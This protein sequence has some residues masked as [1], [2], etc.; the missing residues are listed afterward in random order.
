M[1]EQKAEAETKA[2]DAAV[3]GV[4]TQ[5][6]VPSTSST[7]STSSFENFLR[8]TLFDLHARSEVEST[9]KD[10]VTDVEFAVKLQDQLSIRTHQ[11]QAE[12]IIAEQE[13]A[14]KETHV[15]QKDRLDSQTLLADAMVIDLWTLSKELGSLLE[16]KQKHETM[17]FEY[18]ELVA[19]LAQAEEDLHAARN[20]K[21]QQ[22]AQ[23]QQQQ[24][25]QQQPTATAPTTQPTPTVVAVPPEKP[26]DSPSDA[27]TKTESS[28]KTPPPAAA[29]PVPAASVATADTSSALSTEPAQAATAP[30]EPKEPPKQAEE[31]KKPQSPAP[32]PVVALVEDDQNNG[33]PPVTLETIDMEILMRIFGF[34][35]AYDILNTAQVNISMYSRVDSLFGFGMDAHMQQDDNVSTTSTLATTPTV[36]AATSTPTTASVSTAAS[37]KAPPPAA[38][39]PPPAAAKP[40][41]PQFGQR[42]VGGGRNILNLLQGGRGGDANNETAGKRNQSPKRRGG[43]GAGGRSAGDANDS[44]PPLSEAMAHSMAAKLND[45]EINA[46]I[47]MTEKLRSKEKQVALLIKEKEELEGKLSGSE[48]VKEFLIT[49]VRDMEKIVNKN[50][51]TEKKVTQQIASDQEVIAFLDGRVQELERSTRVIQKDKNAIQDKLK[52]VASQNDK[53]VAVLSDMLQFERQKLK[54]NEREWKATKK[55]LVKE[56]KGCRA[57]I[58]ALQ[59]ERDGFREQNDALRKAVMAGGSS[60]GGRSSSPHR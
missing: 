37:K 7:V 50:D 13:L 38:K 17:I 14:L 48:A 27:T 52:A 12:R 2:E 35:D 55:L 11:S 34:L 41:E 57:Q 56:V 33:G 18:D 53:K 16:L 15:V 6:M 45:A 10:L 28:E 3:V 21:A 8:N 5:A 4:G 30:A 20:A 42:L 9:V 26:A 51:E 24:Q 60:N 46:I 19:K 40:T 43:A 25:S 1:S 58:V 32:A 47:S 36:A 31:P 39:A 29:A 22:P 23:Q 44:K 54:E 59:A 49:K